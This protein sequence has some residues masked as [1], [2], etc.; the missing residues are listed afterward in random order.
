MQSNLNEPESAAWNQIA[1]LLDDALNCLEEKEH[2]AV[3]LRFFDGKE[4]KQVGATMRTGEDAARMRVNRA[5]EKLRKFFAKKG[6]TLSAGA[7]AAAVAAN[8]VEAAPT[9][10]AA[11]ITAAG[12]NFIG[13]IP[14]AVASFDCETSP[15][16][17]GLSTRIEDAVLDG[18]TWTAV[19]SASALWLF[20]ALWPAICVP[21]EPLSGLDFP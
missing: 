11:T 2:D 1:P 15:S 10:L 8:A 20:V 7:I 12:M 5:L 16:L 14:T 18:F 13:A 9:G 21:S 17:P 3:V 6:V 19:A 4:L